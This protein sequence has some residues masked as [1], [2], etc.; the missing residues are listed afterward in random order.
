[1]QRETLRP[2]MDELAAMLASGVLRWHRTERR[3][4][5]PSPAATCLEVSA[6]SRLTVPTGLRP[7]EP[8]LPDSEPERGHTT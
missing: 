7:R 6:N 1:M 4:G 8:R 2:P 3:S 5:V